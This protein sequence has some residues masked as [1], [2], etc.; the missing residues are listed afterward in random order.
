MSERT[1]SR[2]PAIFTIAPGLPFVDALAL[3]ILDRLGGRR[4]ALADVRVLLPTRRAAR[5]LSE[6]FL[7]HSGGK[8][9]LL[10]RLVPIGDVDEDEIILAEPS[11]DGA[12]APFDLP[13]AITPLR[14]KL[15]LTRLVR[16]F[17]GRNV[18][19][20]QAARLADELGRLLDAVAIE[21]LSFA[22]LKT[23]VP[24]DYAKHWQA[25]LDFLR[26]IT[27]RWPEI[28]ADEG[29]ID[30][31]DRRNQALDAQTKLWLDSPP[32]T[33]VIAAGST[34]TMPA[35][36]ALLAVVARLP[37]GAVVLP[38]LDRDADDATWKAILDP[39]RP[40]ITHPQHAMAKLLDRLRVDRR[41][42][43]SWPA[44]GFADA[45]LIETTPERSLV[46][47]QALRPAA[48]PATP[49][50]GAPLGRGMRGV[51]RVD[52]PGPEEEATVVALVLRQALETEGKTAAL[53][54]PDRAL[55]RRVAAELRR[56]GIEIDDSAGIPLAHTP[57]GAFLRLVARMAGENFAPVALLSAL[58]HPFAALGRAPGEFRAMVRA[59]E[60]AAL[61][62]PRPAGGL[63]GLRA[64]LGTR[65]DELPGFLAA[66][67]TAADHIIDV[68][69]RP[70]VALGDLV[71]AHIAFAER[72]ATSDAEPGPKRLWH[73]EAGEAAAFFV[74]ELVEAADA[75]EPIDADRYPALFDA[76]L[77]GHV[78]RPR[79]GR[80]PRLNIWGL[81]E[82]RLQ[83]P[84]LVVLGGLNECTW[85]PEAEANPW[86]SRPM[87]T[88]FGLPT[89]ERRIGIAAHDFVQAFAA[90]EVVLTRAERVEGTPTVP[91]RWL[92]RI[93]TLL[94]GSASETI[95]RPGTWL[96]WQRL[97]DAPAAIQPSKPPEPRP[98]LA[99][100]PRRLSVT[101]IEV[102]MRDP[103]AIYARHVLGLNA[104]DPI[105]ADPTAADYGTV[106]HDALYAFVKAH[107]D[108]LPDD[109][110][111]RLIA[112]GRDA[113]Q[114]WVGRPVSA[115]WW[116]RFER[117]AAWFIEHEQERRT[118]IA[119]RF[120]E[121]KGR[122]VV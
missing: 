72:L 89:P 48:V 103:Y 52:C 6:A 93:E 35:T 120:A 34:G 92:L 82:A 83:R 68:T 33:P 108:R 12:T 59:L 110:L 67:E 27:E 87:L 21:R 10:P 117:I 2:R 78:V 4:E 9:T 111:A 71:R 96:A 105:D 122:L 74:S 63:A 32:T 58:K 70:L 85:P 39:D 75:L 77:E 29:A 118:Q 99:A 5:S 43:A 51:R 8:P 60:I 54:T 102:W 40:A 73:G 46:I 90:P 17:E 49:L 80:H 13:P 88:A 79:Y 24:E 55:A 50:P 101:Q 65:D 14:R 11:S 104:L 20:D 1:P 86:M 36:V 84:D 112:L 64:A 116:P 42:V 95:S 114:P 97:I 56:F 3:G 22:K 115:F 45:G 47:A 81:L 7:R 119:Q 23:L 37:Q 19:P 44:P 121:V 76:L 113:F 31:A 18:P 57:P 61:R 106:I 94:R 91:S 38:G 100:R 107:P 26:I 15:L 16:A 66:I 30:A 25:T 69:T 53:V 109:A 62:G 28:L 98:P 41:D